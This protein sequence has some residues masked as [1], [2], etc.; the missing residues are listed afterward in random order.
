MTRD[1]D[2]QTSDYDTA[3]ALLT[4]N[5]PEA[6][7]QG[8]TMLERAADGGDGAAVAR[9]AY[10]NAAG[11]NG[12]PDW[13][14]AVAALRRAAEL[15]WARAS[16]ELQVLTGTDAHAPV[17][18]R[19]FVA[20]RRM[21]RVSDQPRIFTIDKFMNAAECAWLIES[22]RPLLTP[23]MVYDNSKDG[24]LAVDARS[25]SAAGLNFDVIDLVL[26]LLRTRM[27]HTINMPSAHMEPATVL[28]YA[29][30]Q[31]F[32][33]HYD[34]LDPREPGLAASIARHGQRIATL[35]VY[36]NDGYE[37]GETDFPRVPYRFKGAAGDALLFLNVDANGVGDPRTQH[38]G[39]PP[40][41][42]EKWLLSQW[43][44]DRTP[45]QISS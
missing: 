22:G 7:A 37:G 36:L 27:A 1:A 11:V 13:D 41:K 2:T 30:G 10:L 25:N 24:S 45:G 4:Q 6:F 29:P 15:G 42:G 19:R 35:L 9:L 44:R 20:P 28:H 26:V 16:A 12:K 8:V 31:H 40:S 39:L 14:Q 18:I 23:A 33:P 5:N 38:A 3:M 34:F 17:D 21:V 32:T 43:V